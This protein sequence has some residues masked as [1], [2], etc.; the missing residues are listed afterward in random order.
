MRHRALALVL[1]LQML[2]AL[3]APAALAATP[4]DWDAENPG[5]LESGHL[6]AQAAVL[7]DAQTGEVLFEKN[8]TTRLYPASTTKIM[9][10]MLALESDIA[11]D[12]QI[13]IPEVAQNVPSDSSVVPV[14]AGEVMTFEDLLYG[15][16]LNSGNDGANAI[17]YIVSG[18]IASFVDMMN[19]R[20]EELGCTSTHFANAHGYHDDTHYS[21]ALDLARI[22]QAA[23]Q[24]ETFRTIVSTARYTMGAT[25]NRGEYNITTTSEMVNPASSYYYEGCIGIKTGYHSRAGQCFV[26]AYEKDG[27]SLI[28]VVLGTAFTS[29]DRAKKWW[30]TRKLFEYGMEQYD[31]YTLEDIFEA[32]GSEINTVSIENA[33]RDDAQK[34]LLEL[35]LTQVSDGEFVRRVR[36]GSTAMAEMLADFTARTT[37]TFNEDLQAPIE[38]GEIVGTLTYTPASGE[39][40]TAALVAERDVAARPEYATVYDVLPFLKPLQPFFA[41]GMAWFVLVV[42]LVLIAA[43]LLRRARRRASRNRQR[44]AVYRAKRRA[45]DRAEAERRREEARR[46]RENERRRREEAKRRLEAAQRAERQAAQRQAA[47]KGAPTKQQEARTAPRAGASTGGRHPASPR[48]RQH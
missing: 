34:G 31:A 8:A 41:S 27:I 1:I 20:A 17:A 7:I 6:Y 43:L 16:M 11:L 19:Q 15:T 13:T 4:D 25:V 47:R 3:L 45:Y 48:D 23:M 38:E 44:A 46:L 24:D 37:I 9:T 18:N 36:P 21:T 10:L 40:V 26:G 42:V 14:Y 39:S 28:S 12:T 5:A 29:D 35:R 32:A 33:A 2:L 22:A 30:D